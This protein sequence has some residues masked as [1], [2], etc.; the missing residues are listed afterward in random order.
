MNNKRYPIGGYA[1]GN[2]LC[3][4]KIC[5][6]EFIGDKRSWQCEDCAIIELKKRPQKKD[7]IKAL[8]TELKWAEERFGNICRRGVNISVYHYYDGQI[9]LLNKLIRLFEEGCEG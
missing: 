2:Y 5:G 3:K 8:Q 9:D 1:P 7:I 6:V 4:C